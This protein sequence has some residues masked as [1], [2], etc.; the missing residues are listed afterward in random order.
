MNYWNQSKNNIYVAAHRGWSEKYPENTMLAYRKAAELNVDQIEIDV[1]VTK[2]G[3]LVII[4][5]ETVDRTTNGSG[6]VENMTLEE[7]RAL[8]AGSWKGAE[9]AG[10]RVPTF[11]EFLEFAVSLPNMTYDIELKEYPTDGREELA[12]SVCDRV[13]ALLDENGLSERCVINTF[14]GKLHEYIYKKYGMKYKLHVYFPITCLGTDMT[15]FPYAYAYCSCVFSPNKSDFEYI[16]RCGIQ[17]WAGASVKDD[18]TV[19]LA[20]ANGAELITCNNPDV[21]LDLLRKKGYH[22]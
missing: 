4:H 20:I 14:S 21:V 6:R 10:E 11:D 19:D 3:Q 22:N 13:L 15:L 16:D 17:P 9:F 2:D 18:A 1:R 8:D 5:D 12:Y 7:I